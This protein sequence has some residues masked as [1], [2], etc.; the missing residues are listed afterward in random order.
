MNVAEDTLVV[1]VDGGGSSC[2]AKV[3][4]LSGTVVGQAVGQSANVT[5]NADQTRQNV[6][7]T[8]NAAYRDAGIANARMSSDVAYLGLA[9]AGVKDGAEA[10]LEDF[11]FRRHRVVSDRDITVSGALGTCD[12]AVALV[13]TG[14]FFSVRA[15]GVARDVGGWGFQLSDDCSGA[16]LGREILRA[17]VAAYDCLAECSP[18]TDAILE[19]YGGTPSRLIRFIQ[20]ATPQDYGSFVPELAAAQQKGD[21]VACKIFEAAIDRLVYVLDR[22]QV[23]KTGR[24][25]L[26]GGVGPTY[27][28]LLPK[29]YQTILAE[30]KGDALDG[31][32]AL[33]KQ[34]LLGLP[35]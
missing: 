2:R 32:F 7:A 21:G 31:A 13:G 25:C 6:F 9:G 14:S 24:L 11:G 15:E 4:T 3:F 5:T 19:R 22:L 10:L 27:A 16:Y 34:Q 29:K 30:P 1:A 8:I 33:A 18:L 20:T 23:H 35:R 28:K 26:M 17:T 12:G